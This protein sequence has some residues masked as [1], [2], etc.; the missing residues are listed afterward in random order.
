MP[1]DQEEMAVKSEDE[2]PSDPEMEDSAE[3]KL[4]KR[5]MKLRS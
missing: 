5:L 1:E 3:E 2:M 4:K